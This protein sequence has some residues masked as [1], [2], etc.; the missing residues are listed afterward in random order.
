MTWCWSACQA[1]PR[2]HTRQELTWMVIDV[3][4]HRL[5]GLHSSVSHIFEQT[6]AVH[7]K[8]NFHD[9][10]WH[11]RMDTSMCSSIKQQIKWAFCLGWR[12]H[13]TK[14]QPMVKMAH[15]RHILD[16][17]D[18]A[19]LKKRL[20]MMHSSNLILLLLHAKARATLWRLSY[21]LADS[22]SCHGW[23]KKS[24]HCRPF[25]PN[26]SACWGGWPSGLADPGC[27]HWLAGRIDHCEAG[28]KVEQSKDVLAG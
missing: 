2:G 10:H 27:V 9:S 13:F 4:H 16:I 3:H 20:Q 11:L 14:R 26:R 5:G 22:C 21:W 17:P 25:G 12:L 18:V 6:F 23:G 8:I 19:N 28:A 1:G 15:V 7:E 24:L